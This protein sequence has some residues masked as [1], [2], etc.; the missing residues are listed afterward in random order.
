M[1]VIVAWIKYFKG[2]SG[3]RL[4]CTHIYYVHD[5]DI[6]FT[7]FKNSLFPQFFSEGY[8]TL[9]HVCLHGV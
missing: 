7:L 9:F 1:D 8:E 4:L 2:I 3:V 5:Y 6:I